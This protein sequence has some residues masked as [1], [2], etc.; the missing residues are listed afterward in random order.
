MS[1]NPRGLPILMANTYTCLYYHVVFS[2]KNR[3][4]WIGQSIQKRVWEYLGGIARKNHI[5]PIKIGGIDDHIHLVLSIPPTL[6]VSKAVQLLK[7]GS[8]LW[9]HKEFHR[10]TFR[11]QDG[12]GAF[13]VSKSQITAVVRYVEEQR[14][15][16]RHQ[17][18]QD[19]YQ[20]LLDKHSVDYDQRYLWG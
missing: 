11:W 2:T 17:T 19:E 15:H 12:Y 18:F 4:P 20:S 13:T 10:S 7:G 8:S 5:V 16:H 6:L 9:F 3:E 14:E 1:W